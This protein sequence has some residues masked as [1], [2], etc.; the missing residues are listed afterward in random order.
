MV[1]K[2]Y[3][4]LLA[5]WVAVAGAQT[6]TTYN[7]D[8]PGNGPSDQVEY[9]I[10]FSGTSV[11]WI[12]EGRN[13]PNDSF[14]QIDTGTASKTALCGSYRQMRLRLSAATAATVRGSVNRVLRA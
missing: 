1:P 4:G 8:P 6:G 12:L 11:T 5:A 2:I 14:V 13:S 10:S 3:E 9:S 7:V